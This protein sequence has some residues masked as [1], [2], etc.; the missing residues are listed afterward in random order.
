MAFQMPD[1]GGGPT[2]PRIRVGR[3]SRRVRT[4]LMTLGVL[5]VLGMVFTMFAGFVT[6]T[7]DRFGMTLDGTD[8]AIAWALA[9][10]GWA[11]AVYAIWQACLRAE[12]DG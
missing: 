11:I 10:T 3:P 4:L 2:G 12:S 7:P 6:F 5:A 1:R 8:K 9:A